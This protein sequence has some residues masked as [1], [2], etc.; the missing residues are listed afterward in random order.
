MNQ[1]IEKDLTNKIICYNCDRK[2]DVSDIE[3][4]TIFKC[5]QCYTTLIKTDY[6][7]S[8][9]KNLIKKRNKFLIYGMAISILPMPLLMSYVTSKPME[10][11]ILYIVIDILMIWSIKYFSLKANDIIFGIVLAELGIFA[12][13]TRIVLNE[14][15]LPKFVSEINDLTFQVYLFISLA[16]LFIFSGLMTRKRYIQK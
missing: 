1:E 9:R 13:I 8:P 16:I 14:F 5:K 3:I 6:F 2:I 10:T 12:N 4:G 15:A 11:A 7:K